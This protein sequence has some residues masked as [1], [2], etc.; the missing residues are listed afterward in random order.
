MAKITDVKGVFFDYG[1]VIENVS[2][3]RAHLLKGVSIMSGILSENGITPDAAELDEALQSGWK[4]YQS[5]YREH[6]FTEL[7]SSEIWTQFLLKSWCDSKK[8]CSII[9]DLAEELSSIYEYYLYKRRP[10]ASMVMVLKTLFQYR[11]IMALVSNTISKTLIPERLMK[12]GV[13]RYFKTVILS[14]DT[15]LRKPNTGIFSSALRQTNL[16]PDKCLFVGDSLSSDIGGSRGA[17]FRY[18][19]LLH[20]PVTEKG[21]IEYRDEVKP[22]FVIDKLE[23]ILPLL[24]D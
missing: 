13:D 17:G 3:D 24:L 5:W 10:P 16:A 2:A 6:D 15:G 22:D 4:A 14:S 18:S 20:S 12:F 8:R 19:V 21:D 9:A 1:G 23:D 7:P 11:F